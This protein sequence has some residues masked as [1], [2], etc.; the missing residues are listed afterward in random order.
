MAQIKTPSMTLL[1]SGITPGQVDMTVIAGYP[2]MMCKFS[3][4]LTEAAE[5]TRHMTGADAE[6]PRVPRSRQ[7][8][9]NR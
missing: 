4:A 2:Q 1:K 5:C 3:G 6:T 7:T 9:V 8:Q